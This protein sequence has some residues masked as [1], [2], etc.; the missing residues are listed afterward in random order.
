MQPIQGKVLAHR[1]KIK[2]LYSI[3]PTDVEK[4]KN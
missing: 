1:V 3:F 4:A 2:R